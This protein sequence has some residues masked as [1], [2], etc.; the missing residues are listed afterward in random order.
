MPR[1]ARL[2]HKRLAAVPAGHVDWEDAKIYWKELDREAR[3]RILHFDDPK[4]LA[5]VY[6]A[7]KD[8]S[9]A[10]IVCYRLGIR[11][12][13]DCQQQVGM[14]DFV[15]KCKDAKDACRDELP[16]AAFYAKP[17]LADRKDLFE[18][19]ESHVCRGRALQRRRP[20]LQRSDWL[21][22]LEKRASSWADFL[23]QVLRLLEMAILH[24]YH[25]STLAG[26]TSQVIGFAVDV[27]E[28]EDWDADDVKTPS[29]KSKK[30]AR[31]KQRDA[32]SSLVDSDLS[33]HAEDGSATMGID[34]ASSK[35]DAED[36]S[37]QEENE[38]NYGV[39]TNKSVDGSS[40]AEN[41]D[42]DCEAGDVNLEERTTCLDERGFSTLAT[43]TEG[44]TILTFDWSAQGQPIDSTE[45]PAVE[46]QMDWSTDGGE[47]KET[48]WSA[49]LPNGLTGSSAEWHWSTKEQDQF[50]RLRA[51][52]K[53]TF[54]DAEDLSDT[55][56]TCSSRGDLRVRAKSLPAKRPPRRF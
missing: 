39:S 31:K 25:E 24:A 16:F 38:S 32:A 5:E 20:V 14:D 7:Q 30:K 43:I 29:K 28:E 12:E 56:S 49:W 46:L 47:P 42:S 27:V 36:A 48:F 9:Q 13:N 3:H 17:Q 55:C 11:G 53:N 54:I 41:D 2:N 51:F 6:A 8:L 23:T 35:G 52:V 4:I 26:Q 45:E 50:L 34:Q 21:S 44:E 37:T 22:I 18:Y 10:D 33:A 15:M 1:N 40:V 19:I